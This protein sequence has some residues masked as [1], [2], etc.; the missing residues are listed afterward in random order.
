[1]ALIDSMERA[2]PRARGEDKIDLLDKL[3]LSYM[4]LNTPGAEQKA[5]EYADDM[6]KSSSWMGNK[7][8]ATAHFRKGKPT[9]P[10]SSSTSRMQNSPNLSNFTNCAEIKMP[11]KY[12]VRSR[13]LGRP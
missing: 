7:E 1:M 8:R 4:K 2:L 6:V 9:K 13:K 10:M 11:W 12:F 5:L 3:R